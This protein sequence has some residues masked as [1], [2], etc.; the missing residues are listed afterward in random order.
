MTNQAY[1]KFDQEKALAALLYVTAKLYEFQ[2]NAPSSHQVFK[3]LYF[4]DQ[5]SLAG[6][7]RPISGDYYVAMRHGP[8]PST[9]YDMLKSARGDDNFTK[10][11]FFLEHVEVLGN[12]Y[13]KPKISPDMDSL[14]ETDLECLDDSIKENYRK[15]FSE[16]QDKSHGSA[17]AKSDE[18]DKMRPE[19]IAEEGGADKEMIE[20]IKANLENEKVF[21]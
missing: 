2:H 14:S 21:K 3:I 12:H 6:Y 18:N 15:N 5:K 8:V 17:W 16:L 7:G 13:I 9:M 19:D 20:Y 1:F 10:N 4:A 11:D